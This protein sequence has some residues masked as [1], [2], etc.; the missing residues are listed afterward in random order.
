MAIFYPS[1]E[2]INKLKVP[3]T[4]GERTLLDTLEGILDDS[5]EVYYNPYLNGDRPDVII[6]REGHGVMIIEVKDWNLDN[7]ELDG[8]KKWHFKGNGAVVKSPIDQ[9]YKYKENLFNLHVP[10][11]L[12]MRIRDSKHFK[13][14][15]CAVYFHCA[16]Q[17]KVNQLLVTPFEKDDSQSKYLKFLKYNIDLIGSDMLNEEN[18]IAI[19]STRGINYKSESKYFTKRLYNNFK[20]ILA[21]T[22]HFKSQV[23][24]IHYTQ[25]QL[26]LIY[27]ENL[28]QRI[29]GVYGSGKTTVLAGR[30]VQAYKR[31]LMRT[32]SPRILIL[33]FN[34]TL[35]N[36]IHDKIMMVDDD[37]D[38]TCFTIINYHQFI[39]G[40]LNNLNIE[41]DFPDG[42]SSDN[43]SEYLEA[44]YYGN[45]KLFEQHKNSIVQYDAVLIDEI[46]DYHRSWMEIIKNYFR[47]PLGDYV[48]FGD[49]KQNI[50]GNPIKQKDIVTNVL[51]VN[52]LKYCFRSDYKVTE[53]AKE[54]QKVVFK[55]KYDIDEFEKNDV[56]GTLDLQTTKE[57]YINYMYLQGEDLMP[58]LY[59]I[60]RGNIENKENRISPNDITILCHTTDMVR[61][62]DA[63]YRYLSRELTKTMVE[64]LDS[65]YMTKL[66]YVSKY[67]LNKDEY[68]WLNNI[69]QQLLVKKYPKFKKFSE[70][71]YELIY[72]SL[73]K[74]FTIYDLYKDY[75]S[76]MENRL[77][78]ECET[79]QISIEA[80]LAWREHY[81]EAIIPF[82]N[83]VYN[84]DYSIIRNNKKIN[85][86]MNSGTVKISTINSFKGWES[87][88]LFLILEPEFDTTGFFKST[89][90]EL[91]YTGISRCK[92]DLVIINFGNERYDQILRPIFDKLK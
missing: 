64:T 23:E 67:E 68:S 15:A 39:N 92:K 89:S 45:A 6:M 29:R 46:Q 41:F 88:V 60:I 34:I 25:K 8:R 16:T 55:D 66:K 11:L 28:E 43:V 4:D 56:Q 7:Y 79:N 54:F 84:S 83:D 49:E 22:V 13:N 27:S 30:A 91:L 38:M 77:K 24:P 75:S 52:D 14:V 80:F 37:F 26:E 5:Y 35:K 58:C 20:R 63:L 44:N 53:V 40:E 1:R 59:N 72:V 82:K 90:D 85:F 76:I 51:G 62:F 87:E 57:G 74:L 32:A 48:L 10:E 61:K 2:D 36:Y 71:H 81:N 73:A 86:W 78:E 9:V 3:P 69:T 19:L 50:Y 31:A 65:I 47:N 17:E 33:T 70:W 12:E 21:P 42:L 18:F